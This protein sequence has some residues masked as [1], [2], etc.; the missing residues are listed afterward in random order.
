[1]L[2]PLRPQQRP[3]LIT[4]APRRGPPWRGLA[5]ALAWGQATA[6]PAAPAASDPP[7]RAASTPAAKQAPRVQPELLLLDLKINSTALPDVILV[8]LWPDGTLL[9]PKEAWAEARL[10]PLQALR[11]LGDG[12][13]AFALNAMAGAT[14]VINRQRLSLEINVPA[15][16]FVG[17]T[18]ALQ[19]TRPEPPPRPAPG[20][21]LNYDVSLARSAAGGPL[22]GGALLE[23]VVFSRFGHLVNSAL[24][25]GDGTGRTATRLDTFWRFD[26]PHRL[27]TLVL[28][29][30]VGVAGGWSRPDF[31]T[32]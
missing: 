24:L 31:F 16:A 8:E 20:L 18:R 4:S 26:Q 1:M 6:A 32:A 23:A 25:R 10:A 17:S 30:T 12:T 14:W 3:V 22:A 7:Q 5:L 29:D 2:T 21:L 27:E 13:P 28:G 9:L 15:A 19:D 11:A